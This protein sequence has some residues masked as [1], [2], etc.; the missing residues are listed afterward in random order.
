MRTIIST[1]LPKKLSLNLKT[2]Q[3]LLNE[4]KPKKNVELMVVSKNQKVDDILNL[5]QLGHKVFGENRVQEA[6]SK[7]SKNLSKQFDI[8]L[9][10][11]GPIQSN[12]L[13]MAL[14]IF[15]YIHSIDRTKL[16]D[17]ITK[18]KNTHKIKTQGFYIQV[19]IGEEQQKS[20]ISI[21]E[22]KD[23]YNYCL[24]NKLNIVGLM[25]IPPNDNNAEKYFSHLRDLR[26]LLNQNLK[27]SMGMSSDYKH[28]LRYNSNIIRIG[29]KI[30]N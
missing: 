28:A 18:I 19:N 13:E 23:F 5:I 30:F 14:D 1:L 9:H 3:D 24:S 25:C 16:V 17:L 8:E 15:D 20:G 22:L 27:L 4:L 11:I 26:D 2:Y 7:F 6:Y 29:S 10:M 12:K 21:S